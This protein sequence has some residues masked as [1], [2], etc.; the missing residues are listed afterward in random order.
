MQHEAGL[1]LFYPALWHHRVKGAQECLENKL[2]S[3]VNWQALFPSTKPAA[4]WEEGSRFF[5]L[6]LLSLTDLFLSVLSKVEIQQR[7]PRGSVQGQGK[8]LLL[9][10]NQH[11]QK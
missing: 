4:P 11:Q 10:Y 2:C 9:T 7:A 5:Y 8:G 6:N 1:L 3:A